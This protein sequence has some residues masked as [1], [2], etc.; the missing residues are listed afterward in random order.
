MPSRT[1][2]TLGQDLDRRAKARA[3]ELGIS[4]AAYVRRLIERDLGA[5]T[6]AAS[7]TNIFGI[8]DSGG[9]DVARHKDRYVGEAIEADKL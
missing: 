5:P 8:G 3:E 1:Q 7:V 4:F 6:P 9:S 2:V